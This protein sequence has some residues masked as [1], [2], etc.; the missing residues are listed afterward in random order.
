MIA[1]YCRDKLAEV[2]HAAHAQPTNPFQL[3]HILRIR[4]NPFYLYFECVWNTAV[5]A[6]M[7]LFRIQPRISHIDSQ[8]WMGILSSLLGFLLR[9]IDSWWKASPRMCFEHG[10]PA[11]P[12]PTRRS[13][14]AHSTRRPARGVLPNRQQI[15]F[16]PW[17]KLLFVCFIRLT[18]SLIS[19]SAVQLDLLWWSQWRNAD[20]LIRRMNCNRELLLLHQVGRAHTCVHG[21]VFVY[22][23]L[24]RKHMRS[25][26]IS[27]GLVYF[28]TSASRTRA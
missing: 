17:T 13:V 23:G 8:P 24:T 11:G 10:P 27:C 25:R 9:S 7:L 28:C 20:K 18:C 4:T 2:R 14:L 6:P 5:F 26:G 21:I 3:S 12:R 22:I 19:C 16:S 1:T 15:L